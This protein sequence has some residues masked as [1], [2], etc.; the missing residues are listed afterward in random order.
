MDPNRKYG[1]TETP[2][3]VLPP[4]EADFSHGQPLPPGLGKTHIPVRILPELAGEFVRPPVVTLK[5]WV[6]PEATP[7]AVGADLIAVWRALDNFDRDQNGAGL[8][9]GDVRSERTADGEVIEMVLSLVGL[10]AIAR[11]TRLMDAVNGAEGANGPWAGPSFS[12]WAVETT[13]A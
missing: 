9:P 1:K 3:R 2:V 10:S 4:F 8:R 12:K 13:A 6:R 7:G 5:L 11:G